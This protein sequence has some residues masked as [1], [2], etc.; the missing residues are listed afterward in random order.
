MNADRLSAQ[1]HVL[2]HDD[3]DPVVKGPQGQDVHVCPECGHPIHADDVRCPSCK[4]T[5]EVFNGHDG[6]GG[7]FI[8]LGL[9][10]G[11]CGVA[12]LTQERLRVLGAIALTVALVSALFGRKLVLKWRIYRW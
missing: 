5:R 3:S 11:A 7:L 8:I 1:N 2:T 10:L 12:C 9:L 6:L 4:A